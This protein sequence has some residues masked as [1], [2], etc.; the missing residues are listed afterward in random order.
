MTD[1]YATNHTVK[2]YAELMKFA[3]D[4]AQR[5]GQVAVA[6]LGQVSASYKSDRS[7]VTAA[8][9]QA[10]RTIV[11]AIQRRFPQHG[12]IA[13][14]TTDDAGDTLKSSEL[15]WVI[16]PLDGTRNYSRTMLPFTTSVAVLERGRPAAAA[17]Y[18]PHS[19]FLFHGYR[20]GGAYRNGQCV[21]V[22][23][24]GL[25]AETIIAT[26]SGQG[27][28]MPKYVHRWFDQ[29]VLRTMGSTAL[30]LAGTA[31]GAYDACLVAQARLWDVAAGWL[32]IEEAGGL[33][34][35]LRM[36]L[37]STVKVLATRIDPT[38]PN[39]VS[40]WPADLTKYNNQCLPLLAA[41]RT[42]FP[43]LYR[44]TQGQ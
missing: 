37:P 10:Q 39:K 14:E 36:S 44:Q 35:P 28:A 8:D 6:K 12:I 31:A 40:Y 34:C 38:S 17:I 9:Y 27:W 15:T 2:L 42:I 3:M 11:E 26:A 43:Q 19:G 20:G 32:L 5:G 24:K 33:I 25:S 7:L 13:E 30:N 18:E 41:G 4:L 23:E 1:T 16:D 29:H 21:R 22:R